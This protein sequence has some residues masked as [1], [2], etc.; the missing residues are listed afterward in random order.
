[1]TTASDWASWCTQF[2]DL[3]D[4][5][6]G[7]YHSRRVWQT[8][9]TMVETNPDVRRSGIAE[10]RLTQCYSV[11]E[12]SGVRRQVDKRKDALSLLRSLEHLARKPGMATRAW[13]DGELHARPQSAPYAATLA[14]KFDAFAGAGKLCVDK[15]LVQADCDRLRNDADRAKCVVD[16]FVAHQAD[17]TRPGHLP[18]T[19]TWGEL[20]K[21]IDTIGYLY[22][23]Y[24]QLR[25]PG[26]L[27]SNLV[28]DLPA[29]WD[30]L[31][32]TAW[33]QA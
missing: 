5:I 28:P 11:T 33:K 21:A 25:F 10:H 26:N 6:L 9:R 3:H 8:I 18:P 17:A 32:E 13:F 30:C 1:M 2:D 12:L 14:S 7:L 31:F 22:K 4:E 29:A 16:N 27:L 23:K 24:Y 19:I 15:S 20:D